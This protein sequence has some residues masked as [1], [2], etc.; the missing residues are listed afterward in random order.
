MR[1]EMILRTAL[2]LSAALLLSTAAFAQSGSTRPR[3]VNPQD[4]NNEAAKEQPTPAPRANV[5]SAGGAQANGDTTHAFSLLKAGQF[6]DAAREAKQIAAAD[7]K[8][9]EAWKVAGFAEFNLKQYADASSDLQKSYDLQR[10]AGQPDKETTDALAQALVRSD[11]FERALPLL[12]EVTSRAGAPP[13]A[14]M[15]YYRGLAE[16]QTKKLDDAARS[17]DAAVKADPKNA[18]S[19]FYLGRIAYERGQSDAAIAYLNR[20]TTADV[21]LAQGWQLLTLAYLGRAAAAGDTPKANE[22]YLNAVR[23]SDALVRL[24]ADESSAAL[25]GQSLIGAKQYA[26]AASVLETAAASPNAQG[27][28]FYLLGVAYSRAKNFPKA[29]SSL[30]RAAAKTPGDVNIYRELG[31]AYEVSKQYAKALA[32]YEKGASL[33]PNDADFKE[34]AERVRPYAK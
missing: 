30:E 17:F 33:A 18:I 21:R 4:V 31:Y 22:D 10:A 20:A 7:P 2:T 28:T 8:N 5:Q 23:S 9:S 32:V 3:R 29:I 26:R 6:A 15:L 16:Y 11:Q 25:S 24:R 13:D 34:S 14:T 12:V 1:R 19:L 27:S